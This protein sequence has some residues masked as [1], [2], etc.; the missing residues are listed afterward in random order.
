M[1][2]LLKDIL[3]QLCQDQL[4]SA[5]TCCTNLDSSCHLTLSLTHV[6]VGSLLLKAHCSVFTYWRL[7]SV[8]GLPPAELMGGTVIRISVLGQR[9]ITVRLPE[10][11]NR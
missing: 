8:S 10:G 11:A 5:S 9:C 1:V 3:E 4:R 6:A 7:Y 2:Q